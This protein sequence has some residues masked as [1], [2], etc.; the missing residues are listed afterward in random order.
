MTQRTETQAYKTYIL[1]YN[2]MYHD[3]GMRDAA[4]IAQLGPEPTRYEPTPADVVVSE[5][6][7]MFGELEAAVKEH[8]VDFFSQ[9][10]YDQ[11]TD[12][13]ANRGGY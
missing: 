4:I 10:D 12:W 5:F 2:V 3:Y 9:N 1:N 11:T 7:K 8:A 6:D 13:A